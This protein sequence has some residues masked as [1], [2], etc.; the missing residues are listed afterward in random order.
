MNTRTTPATDSKARAKAR[1]ARRL[2]NREEITAYLDVI[3]LQVCTGG[4]QDIPKSL[5]RKLTEEL[6]SASPRSLEAITEPY[7]DA[8]CTRRIGYYE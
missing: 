8:L 6:R 7:A 4:A 3:D 5:R 1:R 2:K